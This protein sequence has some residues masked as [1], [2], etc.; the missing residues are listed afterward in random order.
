VSAT[1]DGRAVI[2]LEGYL[3]QTSGEALR[4]RVRELLTVEHPTELTLDFSG[5]R[6]VNSIGVSFLLEIIEAAQIV[7]TRLE[8]VRVPADIG[9][10]FGLLGISARVPVVPAKD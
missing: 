6:L 8:F 9:E 10:L 2:Y 1:P 7:Q 5:T 4:E 3:N